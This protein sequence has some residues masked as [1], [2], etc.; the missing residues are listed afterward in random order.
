MY[1]GDSRAQ[2]VILDANRA[3]GSRGIWESHWKEIAELVLPSHYDL[4][5][6]RG[7]ITPGQ[8]KND[9]VFDSTAESA[10][11]RFASV[12]ESILVP[13]QQTWHNIKPVDRNLLKDRETKLWFEEANNLLFRYRYA[14]E[15][16][17][18]SQ[19]NEIFM[20]LGAFGTGCMFVDSL[21]MRKGIRYKACHLS[22]VFFEENHQ[23]TVDKVYRIFCLTGRQMLQKFGKNVPKEVFEA[24]ASKQE[25]EYEVIHCVRPN[26]DRDPRRIDAKG[27][28]FES[29]Y[30]CKKHG[31]VLEEGGYTT[32]P[33]IVSRYVTIPG[34]TYGRSPAMQVL[35]AIKTL[36]EQKRTILKQGHRIVDPVLLAYDDGV[37]DS[38]S[39]KPGAI[40][41]GGVNA[42]GR[43]LVHALP[44]G[45]LS[46]SEEMMQVERQTI[47]DAFLI[48]LFQILVETPTMT[49]TE[50]LERSREK[51]ALLAPIMGRQQTEALSPMVEREIDLLV[52]QRL[53]PPQT[54]AM[55]EAGI[56]AYKVEYDSPLSR[57]QKAESAAG[58]LRMF[59]YASEIAAN[60]QDPSSLD[61]F[62]VDQMVPDLAD[63]QAVPASWM[64]DPAEV[65]QIREG[66]KQQAAQQQ[67]LEAA[68]SIASMIKA[69][70]TR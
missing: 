15:A 45:N 46:L 36:N 3:Q 65:E 16:N 69:T 44:T 55:R 60:T 56:A 31:V 59:Q 10:L 6:S 32:M 50:V 23:G 39:L 18:P 30:V 52:R 7:N 62:N 5:E 66:R 47:N 8:K 57:M 22:E 53:L 35:P 25:Q 40:N 27:M 13:R 26:N 38:F 49:A 48:T 12:L 51:A 24:Y 19:Q 41:F 61:W 42:E 11:T 20:S 33:Y 21:P 29:I 17:Y 43:Q 34:E 70:G 2:D 1:A 68:P 9:K 54:P 67:M 14:P 4:F 37:I 63:A 58:G 28:A 64:R